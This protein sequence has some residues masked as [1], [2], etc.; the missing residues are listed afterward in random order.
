MAIDSTVELFSSSDSIA[1]DGTPRNSWN[2]TTP[3]DTIIADVQPKGLADATIKTWGLDIT[4]QDAKSVFDF[5]MSPFWQV[6]NRARV[7]GDKI[8]RILEVNM[9][10]SHVEATLIPLV[11]E[12]AP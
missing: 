4:L 11:G 6:S 9:W 12:N 7:D 1:P 2:Y 8:Y 3:N 10:N 5:S